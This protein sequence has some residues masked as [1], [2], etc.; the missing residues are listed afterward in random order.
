MKRLSILG[1]LIFTL[2]IVAC[3]QGPSTTPTPTPSDNRPVVVIDSPASNATFDQGDTVKVQS[4]SRDLQG[5]VLVELLVDGQSVQNSPTPNSQPQ[6]QFSVIQT[7]TATTPGTHVVT[8]RAT[9]AGLGVG[10][11]SITINV[12]QKIA[13]AT[14]TLVVNPTNVIATA[15]SIAATSTPSGPPPTASGPATCTLS[16]TFISDVTIPD[17]TTIAPGGSFIKTWAIQNSGTC[18]WGGGY[19]VVFITG[20]RMNAASP[21]P[22]PS[23]GPGDVIN[24]SLAMIAPTTPGN[25]S[26]VWQLQASNGVPF[27]T[28]FDVVIR[29]PGAPPPPPPTPVPPTSVPPAGCSG[30]PNISSFVANPSVIGPN[31]VTTIS[32]GLVSNANAVFL[33][34]PS[35]TQGVGTPGSI[36]AQLSQ[37]TVYTLTAYCNNIP[38][39]AQITVTVQ[40]GGGG[41]SGTPFFNGFFASP[42]TINGGQ[43]TTLQWGLVA[44]ANAVYLQLPNR[45][46]GV[47]SPGSRVVKPSQTTTYTLTAYCGSN[48]ASIS[49]TVNVNAG[50]VGQ[51]NFNGFTANPSTINKGQ[52]SV[53]SWGVVTN[54]TSVV[55]QTPQG[56]SGVATPDSITV[57]PSGTTTYTLI[58]YCYNASRQMSVTVKVNTPPP[59]T[60][61]PP[62]PSQVTEVS[63]NVMNDAQYRV[64]VVYFWNGQDA[65]ARIDAVGLNQDQREVTTSTSPVAEPHERQIV[66]ITLTKINVK[67]I[68]RTFQ[69]C[70]VGKSGSDLACKSV[71]AQ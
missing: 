63:F 66:G 18:S 49:T 43:E 15:T 51:P 32:W 58:A 42:Q 21:Q 44:N 71:P 14:A 54:A 62:Q 65:P 35:G 31:Q 41:C 52:S 34:S 50:C 11:A 27:G 6:A 68:V 61:P 46:E 13:Q 5:V 26:G 19:N 22:I 4:T 36:Q 67:R 38:K 33:T 9:N 2:I 28:R 45:S 29:V 20:D 16:S 17:G 55:L 64:R 53:L 7:W 12:T 70:I 57:S 30:T 37:T 39:Q 47:A 40:G 3:Q 10:E 23:A 24:I 60:Q 59:P 1:T 48:Q 25:H 8:V 69:V 56:T